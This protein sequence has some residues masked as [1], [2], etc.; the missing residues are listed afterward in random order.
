MFVGTLGRR[1]FSPKGWE[2]SARGGAQRSP[3]WMGTGV[4][5]PEGL[6]DSAT[7][8]GTFSQ[9]FG[10]DAHSGGRPGALPR[11]EGSQPFGLKTPAS[12]SAGGEL[13]AELEVVGAAL[14]PP[15]DRAQHAVA[16]RR[17]GAREP[18]VELHRPR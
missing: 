17:R 13:A 12:G 10:L 5:Q 11:A 14:G 4:V 2:P 16:R 8:P 6:R 18:Q 3:G 7:R 1:V 9:P 15:D